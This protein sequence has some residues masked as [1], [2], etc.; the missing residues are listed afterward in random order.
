VWLIN[1]EVEGMSSALYTDNKQ[2]KSYVHDENAELRYIGEAFKL[3]V[4]LLNCKL[5][6]IDTGMG[7]MSLVINRKVEGTASVHIH[8]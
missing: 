3:L 8:R 6:D 7:D 2:F 1:T 5:Q 4:R